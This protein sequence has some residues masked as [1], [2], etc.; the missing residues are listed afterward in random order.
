MRDSR[1]PCDHAYIALARFFPSD[2]TFTRATSRS[3]AP[4]TTSW[5]RRCRST[6]RP[7]TPDGSTPREEIL[8]MAM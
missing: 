5:S 8:F 4:T 1:A 2:K 7:S 3:A 6:W